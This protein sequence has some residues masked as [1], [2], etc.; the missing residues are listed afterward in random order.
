[1]LLKIAI[2]EGEVAVGKTIGVIGEQG[3]EFP[4]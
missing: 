2:A 4:A 1:M 3:E